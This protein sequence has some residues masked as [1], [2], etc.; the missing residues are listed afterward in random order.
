[1]TQQA[2]RAARP[3]QS[4]M[5]LPLMA[6]LAAHGG[7]ARPSDV[8][9]GVA[10]RL[11]VNDEI[12]QAR[13]VSGERAQPWLENQIRWARQTLVAKGYLYAPE[14]GVWGLT[15]P[16]RN[17][18]RDIRRGSIMTILETER[19]FAVW[20][21]SEDMVDVIA[22]HSVELIITSPIYPINK[23]KPY[24]GMNPREWVD[25]HLRQV[26]SWLPLLSARG[27]MMFNLGIVWQKGLPV[28]DLYIERFLIALEDNLGVYLLQRL[29]WHSP[30][31]VP[32]PRPW[33]CKHRLRV[34][35]S[36]EPILWVGPHPYVG[37]NRRVL[38][39]Y[40]PSG[41]RSMEAPSV[42][43]QGPSGNSRDT[44]SYRIDNGGAIPSSLLVA[45]NAGGNDAYHRLERTAGHPAHPATMPEGPVDFGIKL[46][47][48]EGDCVWDP[49][50]GSGR[51]GVRAEKLNRNWIGNDRSLTAMENTAIRLT[52]EG[53]PF[54]WY[55]PDL[56]F[57][58][59]LPLIGAATE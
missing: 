20:A 49:Y 37:D 38:T 22:P 44:R 9:D 51:T 41:R 3:L 18:M 23:A 40:T 6:E 31:K 21:N 48:R 17:L 52:A 13:L 29:D 25:Y 16:G 58:H 36:V 28:Q 15:R 11:G 8:Y 10:R 35:P 27:S 57:V 46:A 32:G 2:K 53:V 50:L 19:G 59:P 42:N 30:S 56:P 12:R 1:M 5:Y 4:Q 14:R 34:K 47:T 7:Q 24:G 43:W 26:E 33:V 54:R 39:P 45:A 55:G